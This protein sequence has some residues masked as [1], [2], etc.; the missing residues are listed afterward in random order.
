MRLS[1]IICQNRQITWQQN[2]YFVLFISAHL[3]SHGS[4]WCSKYSLLCTVSLMQFSLNSLS[5]RKYDENLFADCKYANVLII[6]S[7]CTTIETQK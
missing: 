6:N 7:A 2:V 4:C 3:L 1:E 5:Y